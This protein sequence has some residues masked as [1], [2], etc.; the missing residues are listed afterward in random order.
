MGI[1]PDTTSPR[2]PA[3]DHEFRAAV[4]QRRGH[5]DQPQPPAIL[6]PGLVG[7]RRP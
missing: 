4:I 5:V 1:H 2:A 3:A 6:W 7:M